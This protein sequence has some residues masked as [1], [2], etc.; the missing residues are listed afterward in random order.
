MSATRSGR[1]YKEKID[2]MTEEQTS[3]TLKGMQEMM[4]QLVEDRSRREEEI[5]VE[6][7]RRE[8]ERVARER[9]VRERME[10][11]QAHVER[12]VEESK[13]TT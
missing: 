9:E 1:I 4:A 11:M 2:K 3:A 12:V 13:L 10:E 8:E 5:A 7:A 6:R